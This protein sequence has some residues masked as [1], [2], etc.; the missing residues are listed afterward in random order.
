MLYVLIDE[1]SLYI[2]GSDFETDTGNFPS[3]AIASPIPNIGLWHPRWTGTEWVEGLTP[4]QIND[5]SSS[6]ATEKPLS[7]IAISYFPT[8]ENSVLAGKTVQSALDETIIGMAEIKAAMNLVLANSKPP[9]FYDA[10]NDLSNKSLDVHTPNT[11]FNGGVWTEHVGD[12][13]IVSNQAKATAVS[14]SHATYDCGFGTKGSFEADVTIA[15]VSTPQGIIFRF[16]STTSYW[17]AVYSNG[18]WFLQEIQGTTVSSR[19][20][21]IASGITSGQTYKFKVLLDNNNISFLVNEQLVCSWTATTNLSA[22][23]FGVYA[24]NSAST[25]FKNTKAVNLG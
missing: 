25:L 24:S 9:T 21:A 17:R 4:E 3:N 19:N 20:N 5:R 1:N 15:N 14:G 18:K 7:A 16:A 10:L 23:R 8:P 6:N 13:S 22:T 2:P 11:P 12:W